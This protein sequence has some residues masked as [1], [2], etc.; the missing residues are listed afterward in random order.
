MPDEQNPAPEP[1]PA[2][3]APADQSPATDD[4]GDAGRKALEAERTARKETEKA[5]R[6]AQ[7]ELE[8]V[9]QSSMSEAE[10]AVAEAEARGRTAALTEV[11]QRLARAE[12]DRLAARRNPDVDT[13]S[14]LYYVDLARFV[15]E[16]G[17][18]NST[19][20]ARAVDRLVP[21]AGPDLDRRGS[22]DQGARQHMPLNGDDLEQAL[23]NAVGSRR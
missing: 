21:A 4:L 10:R 7:R 2:G 15:G 22:I 8:Q 14:V 17:E 16:D 18:P 5:L 1:D 23:R 19:E 20:L 12:F 6:A 11:G 9:R 3:G 13:E